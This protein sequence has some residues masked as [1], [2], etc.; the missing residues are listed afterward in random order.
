MPPQ[1]CHRFIWAA[2]ATGEARPNPAALPITSELFGET[3]PNLFFGSR[4]R[5]APHDVW[6]T[7]GLFIA[8]VLQPRSTPFVCLICWSGGEGATDAARRRILTGLAACHFCFG[9][10]SPQ[11]AGFAS[12]AAPGLRWKPPPPRP[13]SGAVA[14]NCVFCEVTRMTAFSLWNQPG[15]LEIIQTAEFHCAAKPSILGGKK[16]KKK[17]L[18]QL[19]RLSCF[20]HS[21]ASLQQV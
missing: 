14:Q 4:N 5:A 1:K 8:S 16:R 15:T 12:R 3:I 2:S 6:L 19:W 17:S 13:P 10:R 7:E 21:H 20:P 9:L 11:L 18:K